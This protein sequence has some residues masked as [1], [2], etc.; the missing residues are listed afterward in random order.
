MSHPTNTDTKSNTHDTATTTTTAA[1]DVYN[2]RSLVTPSGWAFAI[3][4][5]IYIGEAYLCC[6]GQFYHMSSTEVRQFSAPFIAAN[7]LQSLWCASFRPEYFNNNENNNE[8]NNN[9]T[10]SSSSSSSLL[11][12]DWKK[13]ISVMMLGGT[14]YSLSMIGAMSTSNISLIPITLHFGWTTA[15]TLVNFNGSIASMNKKNISN[16]F[17]IGTGISSAI[18]ATLFGMY[19][20]IFQSLPMYGM[21]IAWALAACS[22][23]VNQQQQQQQQQPKKESSG[24]QK[25]KD[26]FKFARKVQQN[27]CRIGS[28]LCFMTS[29]YTWFA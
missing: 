21:T 26:Q 19:Y 27:I 20:T 23:G 4:G 3:W 18:I 28:M 13:M 5:P 22:T 2:E 17:V 9:N 8:N 14:A 7:L 16:E 11:S 15:A 12:Q 1:S 25:D 10:S 24:D 6:I 29:L